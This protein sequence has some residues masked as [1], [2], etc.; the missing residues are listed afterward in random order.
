MKI[1]WITLI[2]LVLPLAQTV[3]AE[4]T[5]SGK[6]GV[7][8]QKVKRSG[9]LEDVLREMWGRLRSLAPKMA[10]DARAR[11]TQVAGVRGAESTGSL[12]KPYWKGDRT[13]DQDFLKELEVY[14]AA[15]QKADAGNFSGAIG[16]FG[17]FIKVYPQSHLRANAQFG[18]GLAYG[19][20]GAKQ[21]SIAALNKFIKTWPKHPLNADARQMVTALNKG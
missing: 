10:S 5:E 12:L 7:E 4:K 8:I 3:A 21:K 13:Q 19:G 2:T 17:N 16:G 1:V 9:S 11:Q 15:Q 18:L 14:N 20:A 6:S